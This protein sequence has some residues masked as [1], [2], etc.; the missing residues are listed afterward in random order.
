MELNLERSEE[1][2]GIA[3]KR[4]SVQFW[5]RPIFATPCG[6]TIVG[7]EKFQDSVRDGKSWDHLALETRTKRF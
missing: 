2:S 6:V 4:K 5:P 7:A 1:F 3:V